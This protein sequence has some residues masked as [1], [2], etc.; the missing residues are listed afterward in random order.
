MIRADLTVENRMIATPWSR[1][2]RG[3]GLGQYPTGHD[4]VLAT[5]LRAAGDQLAARVPGDAYTAF[6]RRTTDLVLTLTGSGGDVPWPRLET[7]LDAVLAELRGVENPYHR[8]TGG[9]ILLDAL[10]KLEVPRRLVIGGGRDLPAEVLA[11]VDEIKPDGIKDENA[12]RHGDYERLS[13]F[14]AAFLAYGQ[15]GLGER[16]VAGPRNYVLEAL[17]LLDHVPAPFFRGRGGSML[18]SVAG[19]L[20]HGHLVTAGGRDRIA[21]TLDHLDRADEVNLPPAFPQPLS[22]AFGKI[23]PLLTMLNAVAWSGTGAHLS[24]GRDRLAEARSLWGQLA[25]VERTHM[26]LYYLVALHNLGRL[27]D[28]IPDTGA[29]VTGLV[30]QWRDID[31]GENYFLHGIAYPYLIMTALISGRRDLITGTVVDRL[32]D[33]FPDLDRTAEDRLNRPYPFAYALTA[34]GELGVADRLFTPRPRYGGSSPVAW[35]IDRLP[36][37]ESSRLYM[38][39]HALIN[40]ALRMRGAG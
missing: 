32:V 21:E 5:R 12:G 7:D 2:V 18:L 3:I 34:L 9:A 28:E 10:A 25:P 14:T 19:R 31:P 33:A 13:A 17:D 38:L 39:N 22:P 27:R 23:Y 8:V 11:T 4:P 16:L 36:A 40:A 29:F 30:G 24:H 35:V 15:W 6:A 20:G 37:E 26:G 1:I